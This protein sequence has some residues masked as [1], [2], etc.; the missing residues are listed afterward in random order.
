MYQDIQKKAAQE[1][2]DV[3]GPPPNE[4]K[5]EDLDKLKYLEMCIKEV[6]RLF[7]IGP[8]LLREPYEDCQIGMY[9]YVDLRFAGTK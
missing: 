5:L 1:V 3:L 4:V 9:Q 6:M 2:R 7:P 8:F